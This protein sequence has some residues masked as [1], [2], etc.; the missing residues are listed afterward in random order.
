MTVV[1]L[2]SFLSFQVSMLTVGRAGASVVHVSYDALPIAR[3]LS[4][5]SLHVA[6]SPKLEHRTNARMC[7]SY[8]EPRFHSGE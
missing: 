8:S 3:S 5:L 6:S 4:T 1:N 2:N 7:M